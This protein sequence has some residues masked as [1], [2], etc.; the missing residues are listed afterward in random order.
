MSQSS[1]QK[2]GCF[3]EIKRDLFTFM[4]IKLI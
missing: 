2:E 3:N 1:H 4:I